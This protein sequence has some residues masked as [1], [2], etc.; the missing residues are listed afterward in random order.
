MSSASD[1]GPRR[2]PLRR[3]GLLAAAAAAVA[4]TV[5][6]TAGATGD[7]HPP[8][9]PVRVVGIGDSVTTG[10]ACHCTDFVRLYAR[11]LTSRSRPATATNLGAGGLTSEQLLDALRRPGVVREGVSRADV[12]LVTIGAN[13]LEPLISQWRSSG[14][15]ESCWSP[16]VSKVAGT[17]ADVVR[18]AQA[19]RGD[20]HE[21]ILVT[22]YW[23]VFDDGDEASNAHGPAYVAWT[24]QLSRGFNSAVC[25]ALR[26]TG[27]TCVDLYTPFK[28]DGSSNPT[29]FLAAD[30][31]HPNAAG[32]RLI[33]G[34]L[35]AASGR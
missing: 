7:R 16:S 32:H 34:A 29:P 25:A 24:D 23:N 9:L 15:P 22:G 3:L 2:G 10:T 14:C 1:P 30:G 27:A 5:L 33:A 19:L 4:A 17:V 13:D 31:D 8:P 11:A 6:V 26:G 12:L 28:G 20:P 35:L 18:T 21:R